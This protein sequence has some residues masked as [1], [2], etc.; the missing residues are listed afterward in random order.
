MGESLGT[1]GNRDQPVSP[2]AVEERVADSVSSRAGTRGLSP[3]LE[4]DEEDDEDWVSKG[5]PGLGQETLKMKAFPSGVTGGSLFSEGHRTI[6]P[7][8]LPSFGGP[9]TSGDAS[10]SKKAGKIPL[11]DGPDSPDSGISMRAAP[12]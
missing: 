9:N 8:K 6:S 11:G 1:L 7:P 4:K 3:L 12:A 5:L 10:M 2:S